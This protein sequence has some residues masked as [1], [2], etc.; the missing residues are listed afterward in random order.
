MLEVAERAD[1]RLDAGY[2]AAAETWHWIL[3]AL[4]RIEQQWRPELHSPSFAPFKRGAQ[5]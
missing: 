1:D 4:E 2:M 5:H 3:N